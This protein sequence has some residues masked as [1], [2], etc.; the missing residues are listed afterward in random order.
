[1]WFVF[2]L[3][4]QSNIWLVFRQHYCQ[5]PVKFQRDI[6]IQ[7]IEAETKWSPLADDSYKRIFLNEN[8]GIAIEV[9]S[10]GSN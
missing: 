5:A 9:G 6:I 2:K 4:D 1:M 3:S 7:Y 8:V 10:E